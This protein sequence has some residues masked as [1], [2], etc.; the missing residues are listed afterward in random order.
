MRMSAFWSQGYVGPDHRRQ[1]D[2]VRLMEPSTNLRPDLRAR[3]GLSIARSLRREQIQRL[4][5]ITRLQCVSAASTTLRRRAQ[6]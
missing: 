3:E 5:L 4:A 1:L 2:V 6:H